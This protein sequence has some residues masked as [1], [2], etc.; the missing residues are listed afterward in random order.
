MHQQRRP[1]HPEVFVRPPALHRQVGAGAAFQQRPRRMDGQIVDQRPSARLSEQA[2][3][4]LQGGRFQ[5][6]LVGLQQE[7]RRH[8]Q[9][10]NPR[11]P[12]QFRGRQRVLMRRDSEPD[13]PGFDFL[14]D[15]RHPHPVVDEEAAQIAFLEL[16]PLPPAQ[17]LQRPVE[18]GNSS[19]AVGFHGPSVC[20]AGCTLPVMTAAG[21]RI[22][23]GRPGFVCS[24]EQR[25]GVPPPAA[26]PGILA[27][28]PPPPAV[29]AGL[30]RAVCAGV[31]QW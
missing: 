16:G 1:P 17:V 20:S 26:P 19:P 31:V 29:Y 14:A 13:A 25:G 24:S 5:V 21:V 9:L 18:I 2:L 12:H 10:V 8:P 15:V 23:A 30:R 11:L 27:S 4:Q 22:G 6:R 3:H 7:G 28:R